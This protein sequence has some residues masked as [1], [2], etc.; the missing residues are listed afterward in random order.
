MFEWYLLPTE[1]SRDPKHRGRRILRSVERR[2]LPRY[3][4]FTKVRGH[5]MCIVQLDD[6]WYLGPV[7]DR[8]NNAHLD[9]G[10]FPTPEAALTALQLMKD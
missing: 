9:R 6:G 1:D 7:E 5:S 2:N 4:L 8:V 10:P 3:D